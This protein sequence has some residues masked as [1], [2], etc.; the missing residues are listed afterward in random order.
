M[1]I[2]AD[3]GL[4]GEDGY[5][6]LS[7]VQRMREL[8]GEIPTIAVTAYAGSDNQRKALAAGFHEHYAKP[9]APDTVAM[10]VLE[11]VRPD[12]TA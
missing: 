7:A 3:I 6:L 8:I 11:L 10:A 4:P 2:V 1:A 5:A 12:S 9:I